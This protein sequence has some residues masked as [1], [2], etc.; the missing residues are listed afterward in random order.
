MSIDKFTSRGF[1]AS[2]AA[3]S[4]WK[5]PRESY[6]PQN[7]DHGTSFTMGGGGVRG[8]PKVDDKR[9]GDSPSK[10]DRY[11]DDSLDKEQKKHARL[12]DRGAIIQGASVLRAG[13]R[14]SYFFEQYRVFLGIVV[15]VLAAAFLIRWFALD[16][17]ETEWVQERRS[18]FS[19]HHAD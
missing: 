6:K 2:G 11:L 9:G 8:R 17:E 3:G 14:S 12:L 18:I 5:A 10:S 1:G 7:V 19:R 15:V 13:D 16:S 4:A